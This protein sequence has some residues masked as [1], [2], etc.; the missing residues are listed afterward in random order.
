MKYELIPVTH[1]GTKRYRIKATAS[2]SNVKKGQVGGFVDSELNLSQKGNCWIYDDAIVFEHGYV[3]GDAKVMDSAMVYDNAEV[4]GS[5]I[6]Q[7]EAEVYG[8][9]VVT[10]QANVYQW[11]KVSDKAFVGNKSQVYGNARVYGEAKVTG[12]ASVKDRAEVYGKAKI[13]DN[14]IV[15]GNSEIYGSAFVGYNDTYHNQKTNLTSTMPM[16]SNVKPFKSFIKEGMGGKKCL[17]CKKGTYGERNIYNDWDGT[18]TCDKCN[19]TVTANP[20]SKP[21]TKKLK[22]GKAKEEYVAFQTKMGEQTGTVIKKN[23]KYIYVRLHGAPGSFPQVR[24]KA[25][26]AKYITVENIKESKGPN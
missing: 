4:S 22:E 15:S 8:N 23:N 5:A 18:V 16:E 25:S 17:N 1:G 7:D 14:G 9:A 26:E 20:V 11:A 10:D 21:P 6:V 19:H 24:L 13:T 2:F 12:K 3:G